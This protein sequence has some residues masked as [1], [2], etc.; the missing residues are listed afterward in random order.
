MQPFSPGADVPGLPVAP[1]VTA[2]IKGTWV[3]VGQVCTIPR[4]LCAWDCRTALG[5]PYLGWHGRVAF[6]H[7]DSQANL[8]IAIVATVPT[9]CL[10][11]EFKEVVLSDAV[12]DGN[13]LTTLVWL[14]LV[15]RTRTI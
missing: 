6:A 8:G 9:P 1:E 15:S 11:V 7:T 3:E 4:R 5:V 13:A 12:G 2:D 14:D 10:F